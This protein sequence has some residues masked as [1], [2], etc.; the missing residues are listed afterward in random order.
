MSLFVTEL[1]HFFLVTFLPRKEL[2]L[3]AE[4]VHMGAEDEVIKSPLSSSF[5]GGTNKAEDHEVIMKN[6][7]P[8]WPLQPN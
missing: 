7:E 5:P 6:G 1:F 3:S 4:G 2:E 8:K